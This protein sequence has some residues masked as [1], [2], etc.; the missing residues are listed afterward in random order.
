MPKTL[1]E[2]INTEDPGWPVI[3]EWIG[4]ATNKVEILPCERKRADEAL[5]NSQLNTRS[6]MGA[7]VYETGGIL[8]DNGWI[9]I[10]GSGNDRMKRSLPNW[11]KGKTIAEFGEIPPYMLIADDAVGGL[12]AINGGFF[13]QGDM[14]KIYYF[15]PDTLDW[16]PLDISYSQFLMFCFS[17]DLNRFYSNLRWQSWIE[18]LKTLEP[19]YAYIFYPYL[20]TKEGSD[21]NTVTRSVAP[22][23][24]AYDFNMEMKST[25]G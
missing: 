9:R 16:E 4:Q 1:E 5:V 23:Q 13:G 12:F 3:K 11:N 6:L 24:K 22:M 10:L 17:S 7:I 8:I 19:D 15:A 21:I 18:D 14:G 20:W 2:L 25:L